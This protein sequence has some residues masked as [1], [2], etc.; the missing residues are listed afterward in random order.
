MVRNLY[1]IDEQWKF[2]TVSTPCKFAH[3]WWMV[4]TFLFALKYMSGHCFCRIIKLQNLMDPCLWYSQLCSFSSVITLRT[5][6][7]KICLFF[8]FYLTTQGCYCS[9]YCFNIVVCVKWREFDPWKSISIYRW[10]SHASLLG[11]GKERKSIYIA[12]FTMHA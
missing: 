4:V 11:E 7:R 3:N 9:L 12:L 1:V 6:R 5:C 2:V 8:S 10:Q